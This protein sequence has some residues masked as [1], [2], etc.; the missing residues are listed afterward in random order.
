MASP[1]TQLIEL[2]KDKTLLLLHAADNSP[3]HPKAFGF[4]NVTVSSLSPFRCIV[5][6]KKKNLCVLK[7]YIFYSMWNFCEVKNKSL[8]V[9]Y[10]RELL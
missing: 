6:Y 7:K 3:V 8:F 2:T 5:N 9:H 1:V 10:R 4:P